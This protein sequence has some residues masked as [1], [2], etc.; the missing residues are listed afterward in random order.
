MKK[1]YICA[2]VLMS[3][4]GAT[5]VAHAQEE[6]KIVVNVP[7]EFFAGST[8][9]PAGKYS[10]SRLSP[11][12]NSALIIYG[13]GKSALLL[14]AGFDDQ[15]V[16]DARLNFQNIGGAHFLSEVKTQLG[17]YS[18]PT[19]QEEARLTRLAQT[20]THTGMG[21]MTSSGTP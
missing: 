13:N 15:P 5:V 18:I 10:V 1:Y 17:T 7:F 6:G 3:F 2:L 21:G 12:T 4:V 11:E 8:M 16:D 14:P 9:L 19:S 20:K